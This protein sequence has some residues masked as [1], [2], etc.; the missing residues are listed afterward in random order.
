MKRYLVLKQEDM[1][2]AEAKLLRLI[3]APEK[4]IYFSEH[5]CSDE[6]NWHELLKDNVHYHVIFPKS[7]DVI[8]IEFLKLAP[9]LLKR[10]F[11]AYFIQ[12]RGFAA[13]AKITRLCNKYR[14]G[15]VVKFNILSQKY[16]KG[17]S[18]SNINGHIK[19]IA[20][21]RLAKLHIN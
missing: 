20:K 10:H 12:Q 8:G 5:K 1:V 3:L 9:L 17:P 19:Q 6:N 2:Y 14:R 4:I 21:R 11:T 18:L 16:N 7:S 15:H 13:E